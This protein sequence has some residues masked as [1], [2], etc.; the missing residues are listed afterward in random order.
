M[1]ITITQGSLEIS[2]LNAGYDP[3]QWY[4]LAYGNGVYVAVATSGTSKP[5][6]DSRIMRSTNGIT[7]TPVVSSASG[8]ASWRS[9]A[10]G[11]GKFVAVAT[12][13]T[14][15][16]MY[17]A[18]GLT[19]TPSTP[20]SQTWNSITY[21]NNLF[22]AVA[23]SG[24]GNRVMTSPD[25]ITWTS[26]NSAANIGW[27]SVTYGNGLFV[28][29]SYS[30]VTNG[31]MTS[32]D[33]ITWTS[34]TCPNNQWR[35]VAY[36][37][38]IF[39]AVAQSGTGNRVMTSPDGITWTSRNSAEN[40]TWVDVKYGAGLF[41]AVANDGTNRVMTS[42]DGITWTAILVDSTSSWNCIVYGD[43]LFVSLAFL[44]NVYNRAMTSIDGISWINRPLATRL[45]WKSVTYGNG[46]YVAVSNN[47]IG[48]RIMTST[49]GNTWTVRNSL[50]LNWSVVKFMNDRFFA[51]QTT[52]SNIYTSLDG[53]TWTNI[54]GP[55]T[56]NWTDAVYGNGTYVAVTSNGSQQVATSSNG[57][58]WTMRSQNGVLNS[59]T[60]GN[61]LFVTV[62]SGGIATSP[63]G[64]TW[65]E[66][67]SPA[68]INWKSVVYGNG[69]FVAISDGGAVS[70]QIATSS[71]GITWTLRPSTTTN[72]WQSVEFGNGMFVA[73]SSNG[74]GTRI[75]GSL[76]G[77]NW[78]KIPY[79][80]NS[81][82]NWSKVVYGN[83]KFILVA[84]GSTT[85][86]TNA[87]G[88]LTF[89]TTFTT[90]NFT[91]ASQNVGILLNTGLYQDLFTA[92][93]IETNNLLSY[94]TVTV[95]NPSILT[96]LSNNRTFVTNSIGSAQVTISFAANEYMTAMSPVVFTVNV[97]GPLTALNSTIN[98]GST[99]AGYIYAIWRKVIYG[100]NK[101]VAVSL[102]ATLVS[103]RAYPFM[104][105]EDGISW[106][107][108]EGPNKTHRDLVYSSEKGLFVAA[109][110]AASPNVSSISV[111]T[112]AINWFPV[113]AY[114]GVWF[115]V[116]YGNG[117]FVAVSYNTSLT[118]AMYSSDGYTWTAVTTPYTNGWRSVTFGNGVFVAVA[119]SGTAGTRVMRSLDGINWT[120]PSYTADN[121]WQS[122]TYGNGLFVAVSNNGTNNRIMSS[123]DGITWTNRGSSSLNFSFSA[124]TFDNNTFAAV[125]SNVNN[126]VVAYSTNAITWSLSSSAVISGTS[127]AN[128]WTS[129]AYGN[130]K[131]VVVADSGTI[132]RVA[133]STNLINWN[134][135]TSIQNFS[136]ENMCVGNGTLAMISYG[137]SHGYGAVINSTDG[138]RTWNVPS[139]P[140]ISQ[141][142]KQIKFLN[143]LFIAVGDNS[144]IMTSPNAI[145]WTQRSFSSNLALKN[146]TYGAG[147]YVAVCDAG[148][149][150]GITSP[151]GITWT[152]FTAP[153]SCS[154]VMYA[155]GL[156]VAVGNSGAIMT[157]TN[158]TTWTVRVSPVNF[159]WFKVAYGNNVWVAVSGQ[160]ITNN[161]IYSSDGIT[162]TQCIQPLNIYWQ[163]LDFGICEQVPRFIAVNNANNKL[164]SSDGVN[165]IVTDY[166][167]NSL[168]T[169]GITRIGYA[170][171]RFIMANGTSTITTSKVPMILGRQTPVITVPSTI[172]KIYGDANFT[173]NASSTSSESSLTFT[174]GDTNVATVDSFGNVT[175][176]SSGTVKITAFQAASTNYIEASAS[177][178]ITISKKT[179]IISSPSSFSK[180][181]G[182]SSVSI[183]ASL[184]HSETQLV[185]TSS[186]PAIASV[187]SS[188]TITFLK[189]G[190]CNITVSSD[191]TANYTSASATITIV[192]AKKQT[193]VTVSG[194]FSKTFGDAP[195]A[196]NG[197]NNSTEASI[198][199]SSDDETV[200]SVD[201][202]GNVT[203]NGAGTCTITLSVVET[204]NFTFGS[205][206]T[207]INVAK[208]QTVL[209][210]ETSFS[211][212]IGDSF[213]LNASSNNNEEPIT[214]LSSND[215]IA[216]VSSSGQ[217][218]VLMEG[219]CTITISQ[220][221]SLNYL[222]ATKTI[223]LLASRIQTVLLVNSSFRKG[224]ADIGV[225]FSLNA[226]SNSPATFVYST[227]N[228]AVATVDASGMV[229]IVGTTGDSC[230][231]TITQ[232]QTSG[233]TSASATT[234]IIVAEAGT[235]S[236]IT[237]ASTTINKTF[238]D[239]SFSLGASSNNNESAISYISLNPGVASVSS[240]GEV[241]INSSGACE[242]VVSQPDSVNFNRT[243]VAVQLTVA[244]RPVSITVNTTINKTFGDVPFLIG[245]TK[246]PDSG[247]PITYTVGNTQIISVDSL[248]EVKINKAGSTSVTLQIAENTNYLGTTETVVININKQ[249]TTIAVTQPGTKTYGDSPFYLDVASNN[250][251]AFTF[252]SSVPS[253]AAIDTFG[254]VTINS[255]GTT[256][257]TVTQA[258]TD[259][260]NAGTTTLQLVI[261]KALPTF[262]SFVFT[263]PQNFGSP[264]F[265]LVSPSS[266]SSGTITF[267][268]SNTAVASISNST[269]TIVGAGTTI[270]SANQAST[271]NYLASSVSATLTVNP[272]SPTIGGFYPVTKDL[273]SGNFTLSN[274]TTSNS[275]GSYVFSIADSNIATVS[276]NT[277]TIVGAGTTLIT[278]VQQASGN[279][280]SGSITATL[281]INKILPT[282]GTWADVSKT[283]GDASFVIVPPSSNSTGTWTFTSSNQ[284]VIVITNDIATI[285]GTG[286]S[287]I[288]GIQA[289]T[290]NYNSIASSMT[291]TVNNANPT[292]SALTFTTPQP[293]GSSPFT[294]TLPS[295]NSGGSFTL[296]SSNTAVATVS[297]TTVTMLSVGSTVITANQAAAGYYNAGSVTRTLVVSLKSPT[298]G[299]FTSVPSTLPYLSSNVTLT[300]PTSNSL[301]SFTFTS[302][303]PSVA[304]VSGTALSVVN[305]GTVN[306]IAT[307]AANGDYDTGSVSATLVVTK[308]N[309]TITNFTNLTKNYS[310]APF[311]LTA[312]S[313]STGTISY[314]VSDSSIA[315]ISGSTVT[316]LKA[317]T[318]TITASLDADSNYNSTTSTVTLTVNTILPTIGTWTIANT[319]YGVGTVT[320]INPSSNS[321]GEWTFTSSDTDKATINGNQLTVLHAGTVTITATQSASE[322]YQSSSTTATLVIE[323]QIPVID[324]VKSF[325]KTFSDIGVAFALNATSTSPAPLIYSTSDNT[326][327]TVDANGNVTPIGPE[328]TECIITVSQTATDDYESK[329]ESILVFI[330]ETGTDTVINVT[331][332]INKV[333]G[334]SVFS[335]GA[336]TNN[337]DSVISYTSLNTSIAT[338]N[339]SGNVTIVSAGTCTIR[340]FQPDSV[341][342]NKI[343]IDVTII[344]A[345]APSTISM[346]SSF[347][348][349]FGDSAFMPGATT[350]S[351]ASIIYTVDNTSVALVSGNQIS[352]AGAG[353]TTITAS[354][355]ETVNFLA[356][357]TTATLTVSTIMPTF[358]TFTVPSPK[359]YGDIP[360]NLTVPTSNSSGTWTLSSSDTAL[361][362][363]SGTN[364]TIGGTGTV[365]IT[366]TQAAAGNYSSKSVTAAMII[367]KS[368]PTLGTFS[369]IS[370]AYGD[371]AFTLS[372][373]S[374]N[375]DGAI[376][377]TSSN[378]TIASISGNQVTINS[379]G[380]VT[381]T[382]TQASTDNYKQAT[383]TATLTIVKGT[384]IFSNFTNITKNF[385]EAA[386]ALTATTTSTASVSYTSSNPTVVSLSATTATIL[387]VG[388]STI[389]ASVASTTNYNAASA[390]ITITVNPIAPT[391]TWATSIAKQFGDNSFIL[392]NPTS[393][394]TGSYTF[395]SSNTSVIS[396][397]GATA[398]VIGVGT[399]TI[400]ATQEASGNYTSGSITLTATVSP[401]A[402]TITFSNITKTYGDSS[403][404]ISGITSNSSGTYSFS[405]SNT[406]VA[407]VNGSIITI[408]NI[409]STIITATQ[410]AQGNYSIGNASAILTVNRAVPTLT[411][412]SSISKNFEDTSFILDNPTSPSSG[413]YTFTSS[414]TSVATINGNTVTVGNVGTTT[415]TAT[416]AALGNYDV[417]TVTVILTVSAIPPNITN[418]SGIVKNFGDSNFNIVDPTSP[419]TGTF[420]YQTSDASVATVNEKTVTV[421]GAGTATI[422]VTQ[423]ASGNYTVG[424]KTTTITVNPILPSLSDFN[425]ISKS[426]SD[427]SFDLSDPN[428][429]SSGTW[430]FSVSNE[431]VATISGRTLT[432]K[433][434]GT[435]TVTATQA[436]A[437][438]YLSNSITATITITPI[439]PTISGF[440]NIT[441][442]FGDSNFFL[443]NPLTNSSGTWSFSSSDTNVATITGSQ[444]QIN[445]AGTTTIT[446]TVSAA[447]NYVEGSITATLT[448]SKQTGVITVERSLRK[449]F[450]DI[451]VPFSLNATSNSISPINYVS[452]DASVATVDSNGNV[453]IV[454]QIGS[455]CTI[456]LYQDASNDHT[457]ATETVV[458]L[459]A[460]AG[461]DTEITVSPV[462]NKTFGD[463]SFSLGAQTN[464]TD[465]PIIYTTSNSLVASVSSNGTVTLGVS[466]TCIITLFRPDSINF[467]KATVTTTI[468]V[469]KKSTSISIPEITPKFF[470]GSSFL[471]NATSIH[472]ESPLTYSPANSDIVTINGLGIVSIVGAGTTTITV[473]QSE[474]DNY[475]A[476]SATR[477][478]LVNQIAPTIG[479]FTIPG[480]QPFQGTPLTLTAPQS[481]NTSNFTYSVSDTSVVNIQGTQ[482]SFVG[483]GTATVTA[484]QPAF[485]NYTEGSVN[486]TIQVTPIPS[487]IS[488]FSSVVKNF[489]DPKFN[490]SLPTSNSSGS[491]TFAS[492]NSLVATVSGIEVTIVGAGTS[493]IT[494]TQSASG[495]YSQGTATM[496]L[497][498]NKISPTF[499]NVVNVTKNY[500]DAAFLLPNITS[501]SPAAITYS[502]SNTT[503]VSLSGTT[504]TILKAGTVTITASQIATTNYL[505][506]STTFTITVNKIAPT[507]T[508]FPALTYNFGD[509]PFTITTPTTNSV[510]GSFNYTVTDSSVIAISGST[511]TILKA[512]TVTLTATQGPSANYTSGTITTTVTI[513]QIL[514]TISGFT[515]ITANFGDADIPI[516]APISNSA[517]AFTYSS[518]NT[519]VIAIIGSSARIIGGG[520]AIITA[521]QANAGNYL[522]G[523]ITATYIV[524]PIAPTIAN[525]ANITKTFGDASFEPTN[526]NTNS[527]GSITF[528]SSNQ[529]VATTSGRIVTI[530]GAGTT[531]I[532]AVQ[533]ATANYLAGSITTTMTVAKAVL[534]LSDW[535]IPVRTMGTL[536]EAIPLPYSPSDGTWT[537][538]SDNTDVATVDGSMLTV[539]GPG[540]S[541]ITAYQSEGSN[542]LAGSITTIFNS[543]L[544]NT[545]GVFTLP[546]KT[547][548]DVSHTIVP[549]ETLSN[550]VFEYTSSDPTVA[551]VSNGVINF[552]K[553]GTVTIT[554]TQLESNIYMSATTSTT[555]TITKSVPSL[556]LTNEG[557]T[558]GHIQL[559]NDSSSTF[560]LVTKTFGDSGILLNN[561][562]TNSDG[563]ISLTSSNVSVASI[564]S[565]LLTIVGAGT[566]TITLSL[567]ETTKFQPRIV[568][569]TFVV[570][571]KLP[572]L[573]SFS[574]PSKTYGELPFNLIIPTSESLGAI[575]YSSS[576]LNVATV[577][578][579]RLTITGSG[580]TV[581]TVTQAA[582]NN[583]TSANVS[584]TFEAIEASPSNPLLVDTPEEILYVL[585]TNTQYVELE[586]DIVLQSSDPIK[587]TGNAKKTF[588]TKVPIVIKRSV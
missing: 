352:I 535:T 224:F 548:T 100:Q 527:S 136:W 284:S 47:G 471:L 497:T 210:G 355:P 236:I 362:S 193:Q 273:G 564:D 472:S 434:A 420:S 549:P 369:D 255:A 131:W 345:K 21:G 370:K 258:S 290:S 231:I 565:G 392:S 340:L 424:T 487:T 587:N 98:S 371:S 320:L 464:N 5:E 238:G 183:N 344:I 153:Y 186:N 478:V 104:T 36:G 584:A 141:N 481:N 506:G 386:F 272:I 279:Y 493:T 349:T 406:S 321:G 310:D 170:D 287:T 539:N 374:S 143:N 155:N 276:G 372:G 422:T 353:T 9:I 225:P 226:T 419:S 138:G 407:S 463:N 277:V 366:A 315:S 188:G 113:N 402:P 413:T 68:N 379:V 164:E 513:N 128:T 79:N 377:Y 2:G 88:N 394:S 336:T 246:F 523:T 571:K 580:T 561:I 120:F 397:S 399:S 520:T 247:V 568:T 546:T 470:G 385:G 166:G 322:N 460:G 378:P 42:P 169:S 324:V 75:M 387:K 347:S 544:I 348:K 358:G 202:F 512:G 339:S 34:R 123:P 515:G 24:T 114:S 303:D 522:Q 35:A 567:P 490:L 178:T 417:G 52:N 300:E 65:T 103:N 162:W 206:I 132:G 181:Y 58:T 503:I 3:N 542:Y 468:N 573:S 59:V 334:D 450:A 482:L 350:N 142:W 338:V 534:T 281:T 17:S 70:S 133:T 332:S 124:I 39:V 244:K 15:R 445:H 473:S 81:E 51:F 380:S 292:I 245:A 146:V 494:V 199:Y 533:A 220:V 517:G 203:V 130:N 69:I 375:S 242:I 267:S 510:G 207:T 575:S 318:T 368:T 97:R 235:N 432:P 64:I 182:D 572:I 458:I 213:N 295:S 11:N 110:D 67:T 139:V 243:T 288:F 48:N 219:T 423:A 250:L 537:F 41:V 289:S 177:S 442:I 313:A 29:V 469:A 189:A 335:L 489:G 518:S 393:N 218:S 495:N 492:S 408:N 269:V 74:F 376:T 558:A 502:S 415:L 106:I 192:V 96:L 451:G 454:G 314:S 296:S 540:T 480:P 184:N 431:N 405:S 467:N 389:T 500:G 94:P 50:D 93:G 357:T 25:G 150:Q 359:I 326:V 257:I 436:A 144:Q 148:S 108:R 44:G 194:S 574:I 367:D 299:S 486:A 543:R 241:T 121:S 159:S 552:N 208:K 195:F 516:S 525:F 266:T 545:L 475:L 40:N 373:P 559:G 398:S 404:T 253:V 360:F 62:W 529:L 514:P 86:F 174:S 151:D 365:T 524:N 312:T 576:N 101:F 583:Y 263:T 179:S 147:L 197:T 61:N 311:S 476:G 498:V 327:A 582:T 33:G 411:W 291:I 73:V 239:S 205:S 443:S 38:G 474:S 342:F 538:T 581:V 261:S 560:S 430:S 20:P 280:K 333:Y 107:P 111:S 395:S 325:R 63:D 364:A 437:G 176:V 384:P 12:T 356:T 410:S 221:E 115:S 452:S 92:L 425:N 71:N 163:G 319:T 117:K 1:P 87:V 435:I 459:V 84:D 4:G 72:T 45:P 271:S 83:N 383:K 409:G 528:T 134:V 309:P 209:L 483:V 426:L 232:S 240:S 304:T 427:P 201:I 401:V 43:N 421:V 157:S 306:I 285:L 307:Q 254:M 60:Y 455:E 56:L 28:A 462:F 116:T 223:S 76:D 99:N 532:T 268:S 190:S 214:Y 447:G 53:I 530:V 519:S 260:L 156:F 57:T 248:G 90:T 346:S 541:L 109:G 149:F 234:Q 19:W 140:S 256:N 457:A 66:R 298:I 440:S 161:I 30:G 172:N 32:P 511:A 10:Y 251:T 259:N 301:G 507:I 586:T 270:I 323:K 412:Y 428:S 433:N 286:N 8:G 168:I 173:V 363:I 80:F 204:D 382:A 265:N 337:T 160:Q 112:D 456:T 504:A 126:R 579:N 293:V 230:T 505:A 78:Y 488:G 388:T 562:L 167:N 18:D 547:Y 361:L 577:S 294:V 127:L 31:V 317:G 145:N 446:A 7:W 461:T 262:G 49:D 200:A 453:T 216:T 278:A 122:V 444:V 557:I 77:I 308:I 13:G 396:L 302:S 215:S 54:T 316:I 485:G 439:P 158:G 211:K 381:I 105:S 222:T 351:N 330:A 496:T 249:A 185:Y 414:N 441:K 554:A 556:S 180:I 227:S 403:F 135:S 391:L 6:G 102:F 305:A 228:S 536:P 501:N 429:P 491:F 563:A 550:G 555:F 390:T 175:I 328:G 274:P 570:Q 331:Q 152:G 341:N 448:V 237:V 354:V 297:G 466:G 283:Y 119:E 343:S 416:Q 198:L 282:L 499:G 91:Y 438:N 465:G 508:N 521:T 14:N 578:G 212:F 217:V 137:A 479:T 26:R 55:A 22:V 85:G 569:A 95:D 171:G 585:T 526:P 400:T 118:S 484:Y 82:Y 449:G 531:T 196:L 477:T 129:I 23:D 37:N 16:S 27:G 125:I 46:T 509:A 191:E 275:S 233:Y 588:E 553:A 165:W 187:N 89:D 418:F 154:D 252:S 551:T 566:T 264:A 229:T 329:T